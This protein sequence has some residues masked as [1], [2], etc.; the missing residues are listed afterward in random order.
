M[1]KMAAH[2]LDIKPDSIKIK[3]LIKYYKDTTI[4]IPEFQRE[5]AWKENKTG[6]TYCFFKFTYS[7]SNYP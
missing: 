2:E 4:G 7:T 6:L 1:K 3:Y 5:Y